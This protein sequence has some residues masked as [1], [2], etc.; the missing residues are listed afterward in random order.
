MKNK[1]QSI[2]LPS[3]GKTIKDAYDYD[4]NISM[5][6]CNKI[7]VTLL[8]FVCNTVHIADITLTLTLTLTKITLNPVLTPLSAVTSSGNF[9]TLCFNRLCM[10]M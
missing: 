9:L 8:D 7:F 4:A 1:I 5:N 10:N 6:W 3:F 2:E